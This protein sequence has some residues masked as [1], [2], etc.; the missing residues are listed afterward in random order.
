[1]SLPKL[2]LMVA[3]LFTANLFFGVIARSN[4][5][6][7]VTHRPHYSIGAINSERSSLTT[8]SFTSLS[9]ATDDLS[10]T[11]FVLLAGGTGSRMKADRPK[12]FLELAGTTILSHSLKLFLETLPKVLRKG[13]PVVVLVMNEQWRPDYQNWIDNYKGKLIFADPGKERQGSVENGLKELVKNA[14][15]VSLSC[16]FSVFNHPHKN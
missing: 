3:W 11:G 15:S 12:Q 1:M 9:L 13:P 10:D 4:Y 2:S 8:N 7:F 14:G 5:A 6:A 16:G